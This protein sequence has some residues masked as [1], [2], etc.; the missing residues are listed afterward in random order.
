MRRAL[1]FSAAV[2]ALVLPVGCTFY[3]ACPTDQNPP[4]ATTSGTGNSGGGTSG[5]GAT[6]TGGTGNN[7]PDGGSGDTGGLVEPTG[8]WKNETYNLV[9]IDSECGNVSY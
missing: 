7:N 8:T 3:T 9:D 5:T 4:P 6:G 1:V 2:V